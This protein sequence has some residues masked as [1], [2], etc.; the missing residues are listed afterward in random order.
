VGQA[1]ALIGRDGEGWSLPANEQNG[2]HD[3][4]IW[5]IH[6]W[7]KAPYQ[8]GCLHQQQPTDHK[9]YGGL[10]AMLERLFLALH[11]GFCQLVLPVCHRSLPAMRGW[12]FSHQSGA[13][14]ADCYLPMVRPSKMVCPKMVYLP[15]RD[16]Q[17]IGAHHGLLAAA[18]RHVS[19]FPNAKE[20]CRGGS[21][22]MRFCDQALKIPMVHLHKAADDLF[23]RV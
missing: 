2:D 6:D 21:V 22:S 23:L 3:L 18:L 19:A 12:L 7:M 11:R 17:R 14:L 1:R 10:S 13:R 4:L 20:A 9:R 5:V 8:A 15:K 16:D